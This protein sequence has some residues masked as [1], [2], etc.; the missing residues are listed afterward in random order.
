MLF[1]F[2]LVHCL[3]TIPPKSSMYFV[4]LTLN[5]SWRGEIFYQLCWKLL[6]A[7]SNMTDVPEFSLL[8]MWEFCVWHFVAVRGQKVL[9]DCTKTCTI[10]NLALDWMMSADR[11]YTAP[12]V[13]WLTMSIALKM[14]H[15]WTSITIDDLLYWIVSDFT[16]PPKIA[17]NTYQYIQGLEDMLHKHWKSDT[18]E[19]AWWFEFGSYI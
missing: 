7:E 3:L 14:T 11:S 18:T 4:H 16:K 12:L 9:H 1:S 15:T 8:L 19:T 13:M 17:Q 6:K 10:Y 5:S 2:S